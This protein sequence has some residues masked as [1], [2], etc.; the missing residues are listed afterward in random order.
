MDY[1]PGPLV[2]SN[3]NA[4]RSWSIYRLVKGQ[5]DKYAVGSAE[6]KEDAELW[7]TAPGLRKACEA[8]VRWFDAE[9]QT[10]GTFHDRMDLCKYAEWCTRRALGEDVGDFE[11]VPQLLLILNQEAPG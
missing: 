10:L 7:A 2:A 8:M 1:T 6:T 4:L 3:Q 9:N 5:V 11:G